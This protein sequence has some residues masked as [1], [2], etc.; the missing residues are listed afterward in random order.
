[1]STSTP[2]TDSASPPPAPSAPRPTAPTGEVVRHAETQA[3]FLPLDAY[4]GLIMI[5]LV[6][7]GFGFAQ[8]PDRGLYHYIA[9]QF[10]HRPWG[11]AVFYDLIMPAFLFM[12]GVAMP[13]AFAR[14]GEGEASRRGAARHVLI[15]C[16]RLVVISQIMV[17]IEL[18]RPHLQFHNTLTQVAATYLICY[19]LMRLKWRQQI[20]A[21]V[22]LL[23]LHSSI[24]L[25]FPGPS[26]AWAQVTNAGA[27]LD[28]WL[29]GANYPW[30]CVNINFLSETPG[31]LFGV[32]V[33][34]LLRS[35]RPRTQ[36]LKIL[37]LGMVGAFTLGLALSPL[38]PINKWL[39]TASY[40]LYCTGWV[41][42]GLL[43]LILL[44]EYAGIRKPMF[45]LVVVGM[46]SLFIYCL[47]ELLTG[48]IRHA[49]GVFS[50]GYKFLGIF[51][52][53]AQTCSVLLVIW[54][55]AYWMYR[56]GIFVKV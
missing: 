18:S 32:W 14:R 55:I 7:D 56:R 27:R 13:F 26:G 33:G 54:L 1:M 38:V 52:P 11:G 25:L 34:N 35:D 51:G 53:V 37:A 24:Y 40:T 30:P 29:M 39:W 5:L 22:A 15:R 8:L 23:A 48:W 2:G 4:R 9:E 50:G 16:L 10:K 21:V 6:S 49:I 45:P 19:F 28:R 36:Q 43:V 42:L 31:V 47:H 44:V 20:A 46:N 41:I 12:V 17:S 3:R